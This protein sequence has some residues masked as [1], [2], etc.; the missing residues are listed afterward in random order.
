MILL[1]QQAYLTTHDWYGSTELTLYAAPE[2][3]DSFSVQQP[4][5]VNLAE[6]ISLV[7]YSLIERDLQAGEIMRLG[8][9]WQAQNPVDEDYTVFVHLLDAEGGFARWTDTEPVGGSWP[10]TAWREGEMTV[11]NRG[12]LIPKSAMSGR[13]YLM[14]GMYLVQTGDRLTAYRGGEEVGDQVPLGEI[15]VTR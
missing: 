12:L 4:L 10:T 8:L 2:E 7:G 14:V 9:F 6:D 1:S 13:Y 11:D 5:D 15:R 3:G